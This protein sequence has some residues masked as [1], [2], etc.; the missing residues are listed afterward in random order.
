MHKAARNTRIL[1]LAN[2]GVIRIHRKV[3]LDVQHPAVSRGNAAYSVF[4]PLVTLA[5]L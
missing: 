2:P 3:R 5:V 4:A 1:I